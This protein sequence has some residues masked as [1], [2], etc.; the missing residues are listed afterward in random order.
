MWTFCHIF[1]FRQVYKKYFK[2]FKIILNFPKKITFEWILMSKNNV[3]WVDPNWLQSF[4]NFFLKFLNF[5]QKK[6]VELLFLYF[7]ILVKKSK[8]CR[9]LKNKFRHCVQKKIWNHV[10]V[11]NFDECKNHLFAFH[12]FPGLSTQKTSSTNQESFS[13]LIHAPPVPHPSFHSHL[14]PWPLQKG[15]LKQW[16][17]CVMPKTQRL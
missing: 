8:F 7:E 5:S 4:S 3:F 1:K 6:L 11:E 17:F 2:I 10:I 14:H 16:K 15:H 12:F 9:F 13:S